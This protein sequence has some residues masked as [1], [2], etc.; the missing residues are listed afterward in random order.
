M[1]D[2][3]TFIVTP[4]SQNCRIFVNDESRECVVFDPGAKAQELYA[5]IQEAQLTLKAILITHMHLDHVGGVGLLSKLSDCK[6]YGSSIEDEV[7]KQSLKHQALMFNLDQCDDFDNQYLKDGQVIEPMTDF[8]LQV[9]H[10]PGHTPGGVCYYCEAK[11]LLV[12]GDTLFNKSIGRTDFPH[13]NYEDIID[14]IKNKLFTLPKDTT[15][16]CGHG[17]NTT[18]ENEINANPYLV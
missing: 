2:Y 7:I 17:L 8:K 15:V 3:K 10:T 11:K 9:L 13:G 18:I 6:V 16:L 14:S 1:I 4:F 12:S 5:A